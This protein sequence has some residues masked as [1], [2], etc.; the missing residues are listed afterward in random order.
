[1]R[2]SSS[3]RRIFWADPFCAHPMKNCQLW[4]QHCLRVSRYGWWGS[5]AEIQ[6]LP[7]T[8]DRFEPSLS[9][10]ECDRLYH[11]WQQ[12]VRRARLA[13]EVGA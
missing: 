9:Q 4:E 7:R 6:A 5:L 11:G 1:M 8:A 10:M 2:N 13:P 3:F 12:T